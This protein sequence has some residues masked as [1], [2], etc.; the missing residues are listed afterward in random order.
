[1]GVYAC[2]SHK[3]GTG[4][5][6]TT[7]NVAYQLARRGQDVCMVD[8]DLAS[9][10]LGSVL[11]LKDISSGA[12]TGLHHILVGE[13]P[14]S[15]AEELERSIWDSPDIAA[16]FS[17]DWHG[18]FR[19]LP[20]SRSG[21]DVD[22]RDTSQVVAELLADVSSRY[23]V[24]LI[25]LRSGLGPVAGLFL[26][27]MIDEVLTAWLV[28]HRWT[29]QHLVGAHNLLE[30]LQ[31]YSQGPFYRVR[32]A[33]IDPDKSGAAEPWVRSQHE[34]LQKDANRL[35]TLGVEP[36]RE[37]GAVPM[38]PLLQWTERIVTDADAEVVGNQKTVDAFIHLAE[39]ISAG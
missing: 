22:L 26:E 4:R 18:A 3:G 27:P 13:A 23:D 34:S 11:G 19:L 30:N 32:T 28:F 33:V 37:I 6:V 38:D 39:Q 25:D 1:M 24:V 36:S 21:A 9:P 16:T 10:T 17:F 15:S 7:A 12:D 8:F 20:G 5:T 2:I 31:Q 35:L 29:R 14:A